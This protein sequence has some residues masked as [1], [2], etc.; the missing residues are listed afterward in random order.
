MSER[1]VLVLDDNPD[2]VRAV[3]SVIRPLDLA[4]AATD[5]PDQVPALLGR[6]DAVAAIVDCMLGERCGLGLLTLIAADRPTLPTLVV[7]GYG[8]AFLAQARRFAESHGIERLATLAK[9]FSATDLRAF[10]AGAC[11]RG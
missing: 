2:F 7:S 10:L 8:E 4:T 3:A 9:P 1:T 5:D 6:E 11:G